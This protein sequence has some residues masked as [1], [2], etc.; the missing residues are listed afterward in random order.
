MLQ[1]SRVSPAAYDVAHK[2]YL[3]A[4]GF[5]EGPFEPFYRRLSVTDGWETHRVPYGHDLLAEAPQAILELLL[6][7]AERQVRASSDG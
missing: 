3:W 7:S 1:P 2:V 4:E 6:A 5:A